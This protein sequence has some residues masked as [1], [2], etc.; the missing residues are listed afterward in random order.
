[1]KMKTLAIAGSALVLLI[2]GAQAAPVLSL[3]PVVSSQLVGNTFSLDVKITGLGSEIVSVFDLNIY[4]NPA[5]LKA[6]SYSLGSGLGG[7][8]TD[9]GLDPAAPGS[10]TDSFDL[11][12]FSNL[13]DPLD[14]LTDEALAAAQT[15]DSFVL[16]TLNFQA[17]GAGVS[18]V[19]FGA[20][21]NERDLVGRNALLLQDVQFQ[22]ACVAVNSPTGGNNSCNQIPEPN[23]YALLGLGLFAAFA[24]TFAR[25]RKED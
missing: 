1:M 21:A 25:R 5:Q 11:F 19:W 23:S 18:Q 3:S 16:M 7:P 9:L 17:I 13:V 20:G 12:A 15:D 22:D 8:W 24:P 14:S 6:V 10:P 2:S 4:F